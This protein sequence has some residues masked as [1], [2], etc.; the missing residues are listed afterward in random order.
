M[1]NGQAAPIGADSYIIYRK[2][3]IQ[4]ICDILA[5]GKVIGTLPSDIRGG[6]ALGLE[7]GIY[8]RAINLEEK[9]NV[10]ASW[11]I[12]SFI[13]TYKMVRHLLCEKIASIDTNPDLERI[14]FN[15]ARWD[16]I[17]ATPIYELHPGTFAKN[18]RKISERKLIV[19]KVKYTNIKCE[20][21]KKYMV[22][23]GS[24]Q[25]R[26]ADESSTPYKICDGC[27]LETKMSS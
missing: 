17:A 16:M 1:S 18:I 5:R 19:V 27:G 22:R 15:P 12:P 10:I 26:S 8:N 4:M 7:R 13:S 9:N 2:E 14:L 6:I 24:T 20:N 11:I 3:S 23:E 25:T 21:C